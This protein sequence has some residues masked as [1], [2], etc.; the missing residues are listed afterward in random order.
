MVTDKKEFL[1]TIVAVFLSL[2]LYHIIKMITIPGN[3]VLNRQC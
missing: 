2:K 1:I 3:P